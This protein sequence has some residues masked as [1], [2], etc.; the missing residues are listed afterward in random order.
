MKSIQWIL[1]LA[2]FSACFA[3]TPVKKPADK[4]PA[5]KSGSTTGTRTAGTKKAGIKTAGK[6]T[7]ARKGSSVA[8]AATRTGKGAPRPVASTLRSR[9]A[10]PSPERYKEIQDALAA[11]GYLKSEASGVWDSRSVDALKQYQS[12]NNMQP[13]GKLTAPALIGLGLGPRHDDPVTPVQPS[14]TVAPAQTD[15]PQP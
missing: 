7:P 5:P 1:F 10:A 3:A 14:A 9:Q 15:S 13:T 12:D 6:S 8:H 11:K 2:V 4:A